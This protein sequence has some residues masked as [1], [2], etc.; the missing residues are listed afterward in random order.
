MLVS[1]WK[2][3]GLDSERARAVR[4]QGHDDALGFALA[5]G[6]NSD[7]RN[8]LK[9]KKDVIDKS[10]DSHSVKSG[11]KK[12]QIFLY[13]LTRFENDESFA[14]MNGMGALLVDCINAFPNSFED[15]EKDKT[16][17]KE[18]LR[19]PMRALADKM[20]VPIRLKAFLNKSI[21][22]GGEVNYL[23]I[24]HNGVFHI[25]A[26]SDVLE[27]MSKFF[28]VVN[29]RIIAKKQFPEQKVL[30]RYNGLNVGEIEMRNDSPVHYREIRFNML[31]PRA[32]KLLFEK[33][34]QTKKF[35]DK[36]FVYGVADKRFG[37]W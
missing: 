23:T 11:N 28:K 16:K 27:V 30:L 2:K 12:W 4:K 32:M 20:Q 31:K 5:I 24:K 7:Y 17:Y 34:P 33:I 36:V 25:F 26:S 21:F 10:G 9:A 8:D 13:G 18:K 14:V 15:Y 6:L 1:V 3:R 19:I 35:N 29:S 22:N 37:R